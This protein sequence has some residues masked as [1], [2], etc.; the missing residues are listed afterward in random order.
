MDV[1]PLNR[2]LFNYFIYSYRD[3]PSAYSYSGGTYLGYKRCDRFFL[4]SHQFLHSGIPNHEICSTGILQK[5]NLERKCNCCVIY[6]KTQNG[7][8]RIRSC[9]SKTVVTSSIRRHL[10]PVSRASIILAD[11]EVEPLASWVLNLLV[12]RPNGK[13][14]INGRISTFSILLPR[15]KENVLLPLKKLLFYLVVNTGSSFNFQSEW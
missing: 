14:F 13:L 15:I 12:S 8:Q 2:Y 4:S 6:L 11:C 7:I 9:S 3:K 5:Q 1:L 10:V